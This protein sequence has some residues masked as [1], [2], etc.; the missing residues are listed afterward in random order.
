ME[1]YREINEKRVQ[2][3]KGSEVQGFR[4]QDPER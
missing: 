3:F 4:T 2:K 1:V